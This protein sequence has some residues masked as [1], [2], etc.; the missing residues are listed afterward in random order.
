MSDTTY[1]ITLPN[2][3]V[4]GPLRLRDIKRAT[5]E[6]TLPLEATIQIGGLT[7]TLGEAISEATKGRGRGLTEEEK[8]I[9]GGT[10]ASTPMALLAEKQRG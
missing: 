1:P 2:G 3:E 10:R 7:L 6:G 5:L 4:R 8:A 9:L